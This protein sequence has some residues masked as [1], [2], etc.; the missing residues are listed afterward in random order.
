[1]D[2]IDPVLRQLATNTIR[3]LAVDAVEEAA[4]GHPGT[5][6]GA[7]DIAFVLWHD[8]MRHD[9]AAPEWPDRDRFIL[10]PGHASA[11]LYSLLH[12][13]GYDLPMDELRRFRQWGSKTPGHPEYGH[14]VGV[15]VTTGPLGQGF[16][17]GVGM[18]IAGK[19]LAARFNAPGREPLVTAHVFGIVSDGDLF[20]GVS[21]EAASLAGH[22]G[23]GNLVYVYDDNG[24]SIE[25]ETSIAVGDDVQARFEANRWFVQRV[26]GHDQAALLAAVRKAKAQT[27]RP[28]LVIARTTIGRGSANAGTE[29][30]HGNPLGADDAAEAKRR[31]GFDAP[32]PFHVP[33]DVRQL[34]A[35]RAARGRAQREAWE[36]ELARMRA[37]EPDLAARW[38]AHHEGRVPDDLEGTVAASIAGQVD[39]TR[40][41][42]GK[43]IAAIAPHVPALVGGSADLAPSTKT[44]IP[45][46][47]DVITTSMP[48]DTAPDPSFAG[49]NLHF[50]VREHAMGAAVNGMALYGGFRPYGSTFLVFSDYMRPPIRLAALMKIPSIFV[51]THDS[52]WVGEDGPTHEPV[53]HIEALRLIPDLEVWRPADG[54]EVAWAWGAALRNPGP[55]CLVLTRQKLPVLD[56]PEGFDPSAVARGGYVLADASS[57][58]PR[59]VTLLA[60]GSEVALA[61]AARDHLEGRGTPARV[62]SMPCVERFLAQDEAYRTATIPRGSR[63]VA[64]EAGRS[65]GW[66]RF[67][68]EDGLVL[69]LDRFGASA[70]GGKLA[71]ELGFVP[72]AVQARI[73]AWLDA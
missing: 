35:A 66:Y 15:E 30:V 55:T 33:D 10:S 67:V 26:D 73:D 57:G 36:A 4:S 19:M 69:G 32:G 72:G 17:H 62:V 43:A 37:D 50:G 44:V 31:L 71:E 12:V 52:F 38:D 3:F 16:A 18:A 51:F 29:K 7:A 45:G 14:T 11:L 42:G 2:A 28:S 60:T 23:L 25:G 48:S 9:P 41:L 21:A 46:G 22:L 68:G 6:M 61:V 64:I 54:L 34:F 24:I 65:T 63:R 40:S 58:A 59:A 1:M 49:R 47:G 27:G 8:V 56:R 53:E 39:A 13:S 5:P 70:P 20:E